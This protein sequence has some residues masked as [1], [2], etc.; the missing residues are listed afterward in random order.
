MTTVF[1]FAGG[2]FVGVALGLLLSY[3]RGASERRAA[4]RLSALESQAR[5]RLVPVLSRRAE[6]LG[7]HHGDSDSLDSIDQAVDLASRVQ[8]H[9][10]MS[11]GLAYSDTVEM[12]RSQLGIKTPFKR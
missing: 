2:L 5:L 7:V 3:L 8:R 1:A 6:A 12:S 4:Q 9:E 11:G 10:E